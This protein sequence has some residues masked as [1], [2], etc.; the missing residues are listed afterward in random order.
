M[1]R[2]N[3]TMWLRLA[4]AVG[5]AG[6]GPCARAAGPA[7]VGRR[8]RASFPP[9]QEQV[10]SGASIE[11]MES[12]YEVWKGDPTKVHTVRAPHNLSPLSPRHSLRD[13]IIPAEAQRA[14]EFF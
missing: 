14:H 11:Y 7:A 8:A 2:H 1:E 6:L 12:Q 13:T 5:P 10:F 9:A 3:S 4:R